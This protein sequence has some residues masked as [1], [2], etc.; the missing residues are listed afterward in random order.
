[1]LVGLFV[2]LASAALMHALHLSTALG[3]FVAGVVLADSP[4]RHEIESDV[5]PFRSILLGLF[6]LGVGMV[7]DLGAVFERPFTVLGLALALVA[8]KTGVI[9]AIARVA[10]FKPVRALALGMLLSQGGEFGFVLFAQGTEALLIDP[11]AAS[12]AS[13]VVTVSMATTPFLMMFARYLRDRSN[14]AAPDDTGEPE[15][16]PLGT[17]IVV[18]YGR[19]GQTVAQMLVGHG[20]DVT[21][22]DKKAEQIEVAGQFGTKVYFGDG[23]RLDLLRSAGAETARLICFCLDDAELDAE[24]LAPVAQAFPDAR[25]MA[26]AFDRRQLIALSPLGGV[27]VV[28]EVYESAVCMGRLALGALGADM[29]LIE[30]VEAEYRSTDEERLRLQT[31]TGDL[32]A[33]KDMIFRPGNTM[34]FVPDEA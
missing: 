32:K 30:R 34:S 6:F 19:F 13:A 9:F 23:L 17:A 15:A 26:R 3:A 28:R 20:C 10:G 16:M 27:P 22:V 5:E 18:G 14:A 29:E 2:V 7:L 24:R 4:Y 1:M 11:A 25:L 31:E 33:A 12:L 21:I 8:V